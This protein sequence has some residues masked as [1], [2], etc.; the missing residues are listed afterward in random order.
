LE[1]EWNVA[2]RNSLASASS[3]SLAVKV[4]TPENIA[5]ESHTTCNVSELYFDVKETLRRYQGE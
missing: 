5:L 4:E 1:A 2:L 3:R